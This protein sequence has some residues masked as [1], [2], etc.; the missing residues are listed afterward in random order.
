MIPDHYNN[1]MKALQTPEV[2]K[3]WFNIPTA[4]FVQLD[5]MKPVYI[6]KFNSFY[7]I[8]KINQF[9]PQSKVQ[10]ELIRINS[11]TTP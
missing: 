8:N 5:F 6:N 4:L 7:Y 10:L 3:A 9:K 2:I 1:I 11:L